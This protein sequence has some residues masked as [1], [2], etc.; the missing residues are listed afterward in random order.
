MQIF[1]S[2]YEGQLKQQMLYT[3]YFFNA[4]NV[5]FYTASNFPNFDDLNAFFCL[6]LEHCSP[7]KA[8]QCAPGPEVIKL[9]SCLTQLSMK[10]QKL[11]KTKIPREKRKQSSHIRVLKTGVP[12]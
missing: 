5:C 2:F 4:L 1:M 11:I 8:I 7:H 6:K 9:F 3:A 12:L 10:F